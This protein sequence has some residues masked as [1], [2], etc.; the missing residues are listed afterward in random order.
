MSFQ[1]VPVRPIELGLLPELPPAVSTPES[2]KPK[3]ESVLDRFLSGVNEL[4]TKSGEVERQALDGTVDDIHQVMI[5]AE[6][7]GI[8]FEMLVEIR[9]KLLEAYHELMRMQV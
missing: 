1:R 3:F 9:N 5:A 6:E 8:A 4:Q 2:D 7:A